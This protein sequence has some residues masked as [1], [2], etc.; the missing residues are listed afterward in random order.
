MRVRGVERVRET[1]EKGRDRGRQ[2]YREANIVKETDS[3][4]QRQAKPPRQRD[5]EQ[6]EATGT[7]VRGRRPCSVGPLWAVP[8]LSPLARWLG[9]INFV[10]RKR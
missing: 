4:T 1:R 5:T 2:V 9:E 8:A 10:F 3:I 6:L 7:E